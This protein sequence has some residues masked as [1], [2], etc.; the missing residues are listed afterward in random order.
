[1]ITQDGLATRHHLTGAEKATE[2]EIKRATAPQ[3]TTAEVEV[4]VEVEAAATVAAL[5][6]LGIRA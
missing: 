1:M 4:E 6:T 3:A 2:I 5:V